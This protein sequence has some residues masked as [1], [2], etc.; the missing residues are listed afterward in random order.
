MGGEEAENAIGMDMVGFMMD[1]PLLSALH[2][3]ESQLP[4]AP[5]TIVDDLL[6]QVR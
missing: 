1:L 5:E 2:F 3:Q 6:R 4:V